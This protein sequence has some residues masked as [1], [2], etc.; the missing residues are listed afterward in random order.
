M[1][2]P[3]VGCAAVHAVDFNGM[4]CAACGTQWDHDDPEP[5]PCRTGARALVTVNAPAE[6][7]VE[8]LTLLRVPVLLSDGLALSM[9]AAYHAAYGRI[10][11]AD[12]VAP[13]LAGMA[14][15]WRV[16]LDEAGQ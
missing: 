6:P 3:R 7:V 9:A 5:P 2:R 1:S 4:R 13:R 14:A 10:A 11:R 12:P 15:A 8:Q 16:F